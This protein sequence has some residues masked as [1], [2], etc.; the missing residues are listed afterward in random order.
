MNN[1]EFANCWCLVP[2]AKAYYWKLYFNCSKCWEKSCS[3]HTFFNIDESNEAITNN[4]L[5][6]CNKCKILQWGCQRVYDINF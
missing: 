2:K 6:I 1:V 3:R 5:P 4:S